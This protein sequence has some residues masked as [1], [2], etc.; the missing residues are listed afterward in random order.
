M[1]EANKGKRR[2]KMRGE[3]LQ[4]ATEH[5]EGYGGFFKGQRI[6]NTLV[7]VWTTA[8]QRGYKKA[9]RDMDDKSRKYE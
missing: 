4:T 8:F 9:L 2:Q 1:L 3:I 5:I 6:Y 7:D